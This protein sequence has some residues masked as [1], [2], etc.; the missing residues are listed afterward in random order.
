MC[1]RLRT[2]GYELK[3]LLGLPILQHICLANKLGHGVIGFSKSVLIITHIFTLYC[4]HK[5][6]LQHTNV[7]PTRSPHIYDEPERSCF[8]ANNM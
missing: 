4:L 2:D 6:S 7:I 5:Q 1:D 3:V 8:S